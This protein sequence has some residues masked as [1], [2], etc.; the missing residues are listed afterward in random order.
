MEAFANF[1]KALSTLLWPLIVIAVVVLFRPAVV[2]LIESAR[3]R[4][5][6]IKIGGQE[7]SMDEANEQQRI[8]IADL[9][10]QFAELQKRLEGAQLTP[11]SPDAVRAQT[12]LQEPTSVLWVDD[13]PKNNSYFIEEL[14]QL[15]VKVD[16]AHNTAEGLSMFSRRQY[17]VIISDMGRRENGKDNFRAGLDL[18]KAVRERDAQIPFV[19]FCSS[20][21]VQEHT[22]EAM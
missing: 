9:Q 10:S 11:L 21:G 6:T 5:F 3:S 2:A 20:R 7:L 19:I 1:I 14:Q 18:L 12:S 16:L 15:G 13:E 17:S 4:K 8:L 22:Q